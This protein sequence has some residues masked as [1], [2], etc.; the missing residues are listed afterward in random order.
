MPNFLISE[1]NN[2]GF[3]AYRICSGGKVVTVE[4]KVYQN[5]YG[6]KEGARPVSSLQIRRNYANAVKAIGGSV[7]NEK[8]C[9]GFDDPRAGAEQITGKVVKNGREVWIEVVPRNDGADYALTVVEVQAMAQEVTA[10]DLL[11]KLTADGHVALY[12]NFDTNSA[13][14]KPESTDVIEQVAQM[15]AQS[16]DLKLSIE[17]HTDNTGTA[18]KNKTLSGQRAKSVMSALVA[19]GIAAARLSAVGYGQEKP[20]ADNGTEN[21]RENRRVE[22][23]K[24]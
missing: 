5:Q 6:L 18:D 24:K 21:G 19:K 13:T 8:P 23:V 20:V 22:L 1:S 16:A 14:I 17:G 3:D 11:A 7:V 15:L 4:G 9:D 2:R 12:I 10:S